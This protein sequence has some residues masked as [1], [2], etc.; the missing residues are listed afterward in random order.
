MP[1]GAL[2]L[3]RFPIINLPLASVAAGATIILL[4]RADHGNAYRPLYQHLVIERLTVTYTPG[5][6]HGT[7][8]T[9]EG[10]DGSTKVID[11]DFVRNAGQQ[12]ITRALDVVIAANDAGTPGKLGLELVNPAGSTLTSVSVLL[13][14]YLVRV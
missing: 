6:S 9:F 4:G 10:Y 14:G 2:S 1:S 8:W 7:A 13:E 5:T 12:T 3:S 11:E